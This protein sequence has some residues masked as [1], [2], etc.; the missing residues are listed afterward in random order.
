MSA[1]LSVDLCAIAR[2]SDGVS[3][4]EVGSFNVGGSFSDGWV[5]MPFT[6]THE[7]ITLLFVNVADLVRVLEQ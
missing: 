7:G 6:R 5:A 3:F 1:D 2:K 4:S